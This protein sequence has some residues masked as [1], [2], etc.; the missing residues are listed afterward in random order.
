MEMPPKPEKVPFH[1]NKKKLL[2]L[3]LALIPILACIA[4]CLFSILYV[5]TAHRASTYGVDDPGKAVLVIEDSS[6]DFYILS[7]KLT[8]E[9]GQTQNLETIS[10]GY[11]YIFD[12]APGKFTLSVEYS[13]HPSLENLPNFTWYVHETLSTE[14]SLVRKRA[15]LYSFE[16]GDAGGITYTPPELKSK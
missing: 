6:S 16:G 7:L 12:L 2:I 3:L 13:D 15:T 10:I 8:S 4:W 5:D 9:D 14:I 11:K 1:R